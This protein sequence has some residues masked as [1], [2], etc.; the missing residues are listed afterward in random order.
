[1]RLS[2][3]TMFIIY[4]KGGLLPR[5]HDCMLTATDLEVFMGEILKSLPPTWAIRD[6]LLLSIAWCTSLRKSSIEYM[7]IADIK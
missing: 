6:C 7:V 4:N 5:K 2:V 3:R 1:M